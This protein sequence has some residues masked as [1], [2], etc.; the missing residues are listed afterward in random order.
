MHLN[1]TDSIITQYPEPE[2]SIVHISDT[3]LLASDANLYGSTVN[4]DRNIKTL[5]E[6]LEQSHATP[7]TIIFTGDLADQ[8]E[9]EAYIKLRQ[10]VEPAAERLGAQIVWVMGNHDNRT[11]FR[12]HL[13]SDS[14]NDPNKPAD[15]VHTINGLRIISLD[16]SV[17]YHHHG[18]ISQ[19][20]KDW[21][22]DILSTEAPHGTIL[23]MHHPPVPSVLPLAATVELRDQ[24]SLIDVVQGSDIRAIIAGHLHYSSFSTF[25]GI[26]VSVASATCYT[27]DLHVEKG[28]TRGRNGAQAYNLIDVYEK[29]VLHSVVPLAHADTVGTFYS[30]VEAQR[31]LHSEG[32]RL[33]ERTFQYVN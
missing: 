17:P 33:P 16:T 6:E 24:N 2:H 11:N 3:H 10:I 19:D 29:T 4:S 31:I 22:S 25:A 27:Q 20:Q 12:R 32:Y 18:E 15:S 23:A 21:L 14:S 7:E 26:P 28:G 9:E 13:Y 1:E 5:F 8:G 30:A